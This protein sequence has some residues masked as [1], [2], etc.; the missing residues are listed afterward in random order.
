MTT[1]DE[2]RQSKQQQM[3]K[4]GVC[5][6]VRITRWSEEVRSFDLNGKRQRFKSH[7]ACREWTMDGTPS[8][9]K[10]GKAVAAVLRH[11]GF[12]TTDELRQRRMVQPAWNNIMCCEVGKKVSVEVI[13][14]DWEVTE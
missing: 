8:N 11:F 13:D 14:R 2:I 10:V 12:C 5:G 3:A 6:T 9:V 4:V 1:F 7:R